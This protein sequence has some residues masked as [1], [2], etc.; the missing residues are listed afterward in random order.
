MCPFIHANYLVLGAAVVASF[1]FGFLWYGPVFGKIWFQ[2]SGINKEDCKVK[3]WAFPVTILG[4][5]LSTFVLAYFIQ[6]Y[7][8]YCSYGA[9]F[10][11]WLGFYLPPLF[12]MAAWEGRSWELVA[13]KAAHHFLN[14]QL[15]AA[16]LTI[17]L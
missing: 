5:I 15:I 4:A 13:F 16:I 9:A 6:I 2:L 10:F 11:I 1:V 7:K 14:L 17:W 8:P 12:S 3:P